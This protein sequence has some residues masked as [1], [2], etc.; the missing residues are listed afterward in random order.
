M[1]NKVL[2]LGSKLYDEDRYSDKATLLPEEDRIRFHCSRCRNRIKARYGQEGKPYRCPFCSESGL[3]PHP[4]KPYKNQDL[5]YAGSQNT[6]MSLLFWVFCLL[7]MCA[8]FMAQNI[9]M[10]LVGLKPPRAHR[11]VAVEQAIGSADAAL[12]VG[13][14]TSANPDS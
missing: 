5:D 7:T 13:A 14:E 1:S 3:V 11:D 6:R 9:W 4:D 10:P 2:K 12:P 8:A